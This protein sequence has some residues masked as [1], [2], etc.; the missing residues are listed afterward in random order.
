M[1]NRYTTM[2][3]KLKDKLIS[4]SSKNHGYL[5]CLE[6]D[7]MGNGKPNSMAILVFFFSFPRLKVS[8]YTNEANT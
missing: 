6:I 3:T 8:H 1:Y 2:P 5:R 7:Y 4:Y